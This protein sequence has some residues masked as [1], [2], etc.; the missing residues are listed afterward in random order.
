[1]VEFLPASA[2]EGP[3]RF[4]GSTALIGGASS[5]IGAVVARRLAAEGAKVALLSR[6]ENVLDTLAESIRADGGTALV[7]PADLT[8][9]SE[10]QTAVE[11]T[12]ESF[13]PVDHLV[14]CAVDATNQ[15]FLE[16]QSEQQWMRTLDVTLNGA[17]RLCRAVVPRMVDRRHGSIVLVSSVAGLRGLP[18]NTS[19]CAAKH[20]VLGLGKALAMELGPAGVRVNS[21]CPGIVDAPGTTDISRYAGSFM[22]SLAKHHGP[23]DL[24]WDRYLRRAVASTALRR[25]IDPSEVA[26]VI[27]F[28]LSDDADGITGQS[29]VI[30]GGAA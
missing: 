18:A 5:G 9:M 6:R 11:R 7:I 21:V 19:Y 10:V 27:A 25:L 12:F 17:F 1:M 4:V 13:G 28:L 8:S 22:A 14:N 15:V 23:A 26:S 20:G 3:R 16:E 29:I 24:T 30:D 2:C